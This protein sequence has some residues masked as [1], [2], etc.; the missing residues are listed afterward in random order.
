MSN[1][2]RSPVH[3][4]PHARLRPVAPHE[5]AWTHGFWADKFALCTDVTIPSMRRAL[6]HSDNAACFSN[7][8]V[9]AGLRAGAHQGLSASDGDCF[10]WMEAVAHA[11]GMIRDPK[12][13]SLLDEHIA[14]VA[15]A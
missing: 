7:F 11:C 8:H 6:D 5:A 10:K 3:H 13:D 1:I 2:A 4:S 9:A 12:L 15:P 14:V